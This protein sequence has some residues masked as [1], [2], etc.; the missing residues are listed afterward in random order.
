MI[1][2]FKAR[3]G[4]VWF[5]ARNRALEAKDGIYETNDP[6][7]ID[8]LTAQGYTGICAAEE[9]TTEAG[10]GNE[11]TAP[12]SVPVDAAEE[13]QPELSLQDMTIKELR[14]IAKDLNIPYYT[15]MNKAGLAEAIKEAQNSSADAAEK[16]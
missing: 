10:P 6:S 1:F 7:E 14:M 13:T 8:F 5:P 2:N 15:T 3:N 11:T 4:A 9:K 16:E 12:E